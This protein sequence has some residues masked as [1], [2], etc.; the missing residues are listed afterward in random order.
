MNKLLLFPLAFMFIITIFSS[1]SLGETYLGSSGNYSS[2]DEITVGNESG[3]VDIPGAGE[4]EFDIWDSLGVIVILNVAIVIGIVAG[5]HILG[6]GITNFSQSLIF[7]AILFLGLW[8]CLSVTSGMYFFTD[9]I[10]M[11]L[12]IGLTMTYVIG[13]SLHLNK[14]GD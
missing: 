2:T 10:A 1:I 7:N 13:L 8:A 6:S 14:A 11:L 12:W 9:T 5:I 3:S 4:H